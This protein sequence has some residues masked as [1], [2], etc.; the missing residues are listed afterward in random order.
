MLQR[1]A[2]KKGNGNSPLETSLL[3]L[4]RPICCSFGLQ[5]PFFVAGNEIVVV[6]LGGVEEMKVKKLGFFEVLRAI[7]MEFRVEPWR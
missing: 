4:L 2:Q 3:L 1:K 5:E 6:G 7:T